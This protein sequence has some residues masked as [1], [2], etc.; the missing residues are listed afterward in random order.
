MS[1]KNFLNWSLFSKSPIY[2]NQKNLLRVFTVKPTK[3]KKHQFCCTKPKWQSPQSAKKKKFRPTC[4]IDEKL[5]TRW[6][7]LINLAIPSLWW[8]RPHDS[9][10]KFKLPIFPQFHIVVFSVL[11]AT[12]VLTIHRSTFF[13]GNF[14]TCLTWHYFRTSRINWFNYSG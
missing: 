13:F 1:H 10:Y 5:D 8:Q 14:F 12:I 6:P 2:I 9:L 7:Y 4:S 11:L 3:K